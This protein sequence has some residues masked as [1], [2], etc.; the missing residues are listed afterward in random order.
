[1]AK[2]KPR[3]YRVLMT[4]WLVLLALGLALLVYAYITGAS[5]LRPLVP[6]TLL[7]RL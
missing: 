7:A 3:A 4:L 2:G 1:M 6:P 5:P